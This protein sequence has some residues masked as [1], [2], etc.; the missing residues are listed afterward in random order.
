[1]ADDENVAPDEG[2]T[3]EEVTQQVEDK[4][5]S[6]DFDKPE[7]PLAGGQQASEPVDGEVTETLAGETEPSK[8]AQNEDDR[9]RHIAAFQQRQ[10]V[11]AKEAA[12]FNQSQQEMAK[13]LGNA[14]AVV[15]NKI[16]RPPDPGL[17]DVDPF[18]YQRQKVRYDE[19]IGEL[20]KLQYMQAQH[21]QRAVYQQR[22]EIAKRS[23]YEEQV[24]SV[25]TIR[26]GSEKSSQT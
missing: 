10:Q 17:V 6:F 2:M 26:I 1:M 7:K 11:F 24:R 3:P 18:E 19:G 5:G 13:L 16:P 8:P 14:V 15:Q 4:L 12:S 9:E 21:H 22:Q 25:P 20:Q 23:Y